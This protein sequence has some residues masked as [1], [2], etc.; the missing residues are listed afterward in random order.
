MIS[1]CNGV[2][3]RNLSVS[4]CREGSHDHSNRGEKAYSTAC[5]LA[6]SGIPTRRYSV[7]DGCVPPKSNHNVLAV[8]QDRLCRGSHRGP[9]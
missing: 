1:Q 6:T 9:N 4:C 2:G 8:A 3:G 5:I 7:D